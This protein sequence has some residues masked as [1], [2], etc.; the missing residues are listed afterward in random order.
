MLIRSHL[1]L[2][3]AVDRSNK[4]Y[5]VELYEK[6]W[7]CRIHPIGEDATGS[8]VRPVFRLSALQHL[9][10]ASHYASLRLAIRKI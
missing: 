5:S 6:L 4:P 3:T 7:H 9:V 10:I 1:N 8:G 2:E